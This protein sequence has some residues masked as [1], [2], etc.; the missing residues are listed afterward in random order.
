[1]LREIIADNCYLQNAQNYYPWNA[2]I[3]TEIDAN[4]YA[5][6]FIIQTTVY[7]QHS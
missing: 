6:V 3:K 5:I 2:P 4:V 7:V 1:M